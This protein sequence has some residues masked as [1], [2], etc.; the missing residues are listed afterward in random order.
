VEA[1]QGTVMVSEAVRRYVFLFQVRITMV[2][3]T[4]L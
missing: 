4:S 2:S 3:R 1:V